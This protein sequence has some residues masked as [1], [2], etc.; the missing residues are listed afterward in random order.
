MV[1]FLF[2]KVRTSLL[3]LNHCFYRADDS[4]LLEYFCITAQALLFLS[5]LLVKASWKLQALAAP[6]CSSGD[7]WI[8]FSLSYFSS[9]FHRSP[10]SLSSLAFSEINEKHPFPSLFKCFSLVENLWR[11][12]LAIL[13]PLTFSPAARH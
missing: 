12:L 8:I 7:K 5:H 4:K 6:T 3:G 10:F 9:A 11:G 13:M 1:L 2:G